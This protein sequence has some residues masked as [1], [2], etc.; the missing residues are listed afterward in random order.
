M[1]T[2]TSWAATAQMAGEAW[3]RRAV[4]TH[5]AGRTIDTAVET[6]SE[7]RETLEQSPSIP[8][9]QRV[10]AREHLQNLAATIEEM[11]KAIRSGDRAR[12]QE[13]VQQLT[14]QKQALL[15]FL[16]NAGARP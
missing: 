3:V 5:Y 4:P 16:E 8:P 14:A 15:N 11:R 6:L 12:V 9:D 13:Q 1:Q 2:A 7:T 10:K